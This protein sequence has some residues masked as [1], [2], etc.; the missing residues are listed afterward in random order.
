MTSIDATGDDVDD[1]D[2]TSMQF[3][4]EAHDN[5]TS[6][7]AGD[8]KEHGKLVRDILEAKKDVEDDMRESNQDNGDS[9]CIC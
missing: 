3:V 2:D 6:N 5:E 8:G 7:G 4:S 1:D 9:R